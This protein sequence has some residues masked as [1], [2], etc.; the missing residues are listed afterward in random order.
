MAEVSDK[1]F[2]TKWV[3]Y[4]SALGI[5]IMATSFLGIYQ[6]F[7]AA[8]I[9][10]IVMSV[11]F[12]FTGILTG[13]I[14]DGVVMRESAAAGGVVA[15]GTAGL[16]SIFGG[17]VDIDTTT[18][19]LGLIGGV[20]LTFLGAWAGEQMQGEGGVLDNDYKIMGVRWKWVFVGVILGFSL[21]VLFSII[22]APLFGVDLNIA[23]Y[24]FC[25]STLLMGVA[26]ALFS[27]GITIA[28][29]AMAG[30]IAVFLEWLFV[31]FGM[32]LH[33]ETTPLLIGL[34]LGFLLTLIGSFLGEKFQNS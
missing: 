14:S 6:T 23:F 25:F 8:P 32:E 29:P 13:Y 5:A 11:A 27:P 9:Q 30:V 34:G 20:C 10:L 12:I 2:H 24:M 28:E 3:L 17:K 4:G 18:L 33:V 15:L 1:T 22:F 31:E 7:K 21:N 16:V 19:V 26:V